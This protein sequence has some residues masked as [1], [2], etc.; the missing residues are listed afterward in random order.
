M[1]TETGTR[2]VLQAAELVDL[3]PDEPRTAWFDVATVVVEARTKRA[4]ALRR[5]AREAGL[6]PGEEGLQVRL[7]DAETAEATTLLPP[8]P[9]PGPRQVRL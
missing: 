2:Y 5:A 9:V 1:T 6:E 3:E 7:L 4:T 8:A